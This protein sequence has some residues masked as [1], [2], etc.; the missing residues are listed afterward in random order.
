MLRKCKL[1]GMLTPNQMEALSALASVAAQVPENFWRPRA[2]GAYR[3]SHH[4]KT[5]IALCQAGLA[6]KREANATEAPARPTF[7]YRITE[8]GL[9]ALEVFKLF[10]DVPPEAIPGR[11]VDVSRAR[12]AQRLAAA[13]H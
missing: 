4:A 11:A 5:L 3:G 9:E 10:R 1:L 12:L 6:E 2:L 8:A 13:H 7:E